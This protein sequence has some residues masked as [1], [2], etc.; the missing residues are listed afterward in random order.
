MK[1]MKCPHCHCIGSMYICKACNTVYCRNCKK[2]IA[3]QSIEVK[4]MYSI[5]PICKVHKKPEEC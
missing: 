2:T 1:R 3:G 5:C 4:T